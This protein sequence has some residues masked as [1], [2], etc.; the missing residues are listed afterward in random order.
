ME[1]NLL[2]KESVHQDC[3]ISRRQSR[4]IRHVSLQDY[5]STGHLQAFFAKPFLESPESLRVLELGIGTGGTAIRLA[6]VGHQV[7]GIDISPKSIEY[8]RKGA[9][10]AGVTERV[11]FRLCDAT[12][13]SSTFEE[14]EFDVICGIGV[15]HH[16]SPLQ[17]V[18]M[19]IRDLSPK[20]VAFIEALGTN[21][22]YALLRKRMVGKSHTEDEHPLLEGDLRFMRGLFPGMRMLFGG[23]SAPHHRLRFGFLPRIDH[24][25][26][27]RGPFWRFAKTVA[28][29]W[30]DT[31]N[32]C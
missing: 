9:E 23:A 1:G 22:L 29:V 12:K 15:L 20:K 24:V 3:K 31:L 30:E 21:P 16:L 25:F 27:N 10:E 18:L 4:P 6:G 26:S 17:S 19:Q 8:A 14:G 28:M 13:L 2:R 32:T 11:E 5:S 7:C